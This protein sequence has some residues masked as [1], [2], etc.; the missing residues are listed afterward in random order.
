MW[1]PTASMAEIYKKV[2]EN[3]HVTYSNVPLKGASK[4]NL[5][6][7]PPSSGGARAAKTPTPESFPKVDNKTQTQRDDKRREILLAELDAEKKALETAKQA[8]QEGEANP[9][10]SVGAGG[11]R[12]RNVVKFEEKM[13]KLKTDVD[14]HQ[15]NVELLQKELNNL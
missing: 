9:E 12:F 11:K 2:D 3:G 7:N 14:T 13:A 6:P 4:L 8:Y 5:D 15:R 1:V 10:V